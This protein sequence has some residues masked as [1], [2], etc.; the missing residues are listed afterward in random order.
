MGLYWGTFPRHICTGTVSCYWRQRCKTLPNAIRPPHWVFSKWD[1][2]VTRRHIN[3]LECVLLSLSSSL[4][5][6]QSKI[7]TALICHVDFYM[8]KSDGATK[9]NILFIGP[10][11]HNAKSTRRAHEWGNERCIK[12][13]ML[14]LFSVHFRLKV[15]TLFFRDHI[16]K[17][18]Q[19]LSKV[20][21]SLK[22]HLWLSCDCPLSLVWLS[23]C[24]VV[25]HSGL[26]Y[27]L[28]KWQIAV[29]LRDLSCSSALH[30]HYTKS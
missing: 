25:C 14:D 8:C 19:H 7:H 3:P 10:Y 18:P 12:D 28:I 5:T 2:A 4:M 24:R 17:Q 13:L 9:R 6:F 21:R 26:V 30:L 27:A 16:L 15:G 22:T 29:V 1:K 23:S 11:T 20:S